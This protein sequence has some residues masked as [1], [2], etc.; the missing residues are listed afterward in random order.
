VTVHPAALVF[1]NVA[2]AYERGRPDYPREL[3]DWLVARGDVARDRTVVDLGAGTGKLTRLL[4]GHGARVVAVEPLA[5]MRAELEAV[6][7][8]AEVLSGTAERIPL[9]DASCD[10]LTCG[11]AF[12]WF[13]TAPALEE[14][15]RVIRPRGSLVLVWN[16]RD[17][18]DPIQRRLGELLAEH[19]DA[20]PSYARGDW[21]EALAACSTFE[22]DGELTSRTTRALDRAGLLDRVEST[23][24][25]AAI[26]GQERAELLARVASLVPGDGRVELAYVT[27]AYAYSRRDAMMAR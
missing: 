23:S 3:L 7:P 11:Q 1:A 20:G 19:E 16:V 4:A 12:H 15:A 27:R 6:V 24:Y 5:E 18:R 26:A 13:A 9:P 8:Q 22:P 21:R 14:I 10:L 17:E 2:A 25:V